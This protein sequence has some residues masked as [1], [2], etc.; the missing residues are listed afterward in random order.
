MNPAMREGVLTVTVKNVVP[1]PKGVESPFVKVIAF[2]TN[3]RAFRAPS[4]PRGSPRRGPSPAIPVRPPAGRAA[5]VTGG[6]PLRVSRCAWAPCILRSSRRASR[7]NLRTRTSGAGALLPY[8]KTRAPRCTC[9]HTHTLTAGAAPPLMCALE[10]R[11]TRLH[12]LGDQAQLHL[13]LRDW[14]RPLSSAALGE[15][16]LPLSSL[17]SSELDGREQTASHLLLDG[18]DPARGPERAPHR[19]PLRIDLSI[20]F[21]PQSRTPRRPRPPAPAR[22]R[23]RPPA[24][25][26][27]RPRPP[28][29]ARALTHV[30]RV[31]RAASTCGKSGSRGWRATS[32]PTGASS[33]RALRAAAPSTSR[34]RRRCTPTPHCA[35]P[36]SPATFPGS[37]IT[38]PSTTSAPAP[39]PAPGP[40]LAR[41]QRATQRAA[42]P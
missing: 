9:T 30:P 27:A 10:C 25:A 12:L 19:R 31:N 8:R 13:E 5:P 39:L 23:P 15:L 6:D 21:P 29:P 36:P 14:R 1:L 24:P 11:M 16:A 7:K 26:R 37:A 40:T 38:P 4:L 20:R 2:T 32:T 28:A 17:V 3:P 41:A 35:K 34:A 42:D 18:S 33:R 22:A